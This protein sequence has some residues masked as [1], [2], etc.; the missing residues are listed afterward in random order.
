LAEA[1]RCQMTGPVR[2]SQPRTRETTSGPPARPRVTYAGDRNWN[3]TDGRS[4]RNSQSKRNEAEAGLGQDRIAEVLDAGRTALRVD[5][6][7]KSITIFQC[8]VGAREDVGI[9]ATDLADLH[10]APR[11]MRHVGETHADHGRFRDIHHQIIEVLSVGARITAGTQPF[12]FGDRF[13]ISR[14]YEH[15]L[16]GQHIFRPRQQVCALPAKRDELQSGGYLWHELGDRH[17]SELV[18]S[19]GKLGRGQPLRLRY[20]DLRP[21]QQLE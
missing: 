8:E 5:Q 10:R 16:L 19:R 7:T 6:Q 1:G 15:I 3:E 2:P 21:Q 13:R 9:A 17:A 20:Y 4:E 14:D 11:R 18:G 12:Q